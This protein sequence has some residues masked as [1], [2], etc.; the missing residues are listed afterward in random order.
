MVARSIEFAYEAREKLDVPAYSNQMSAYDIKL[1][2][3]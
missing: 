1:R 2:L 3:S